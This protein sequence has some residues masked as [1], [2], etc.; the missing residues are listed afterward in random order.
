MNT[1]LGP[2]QIQNQFNSINFNFIVPNANLLL[3]AFHIQII[4]QIL[5]LRVERALSA[6]GE[7]ALCEE[8]DRSAFKC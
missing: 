6:I 5:C 3:L 2:L 1:A 4:D 7:T 8:A